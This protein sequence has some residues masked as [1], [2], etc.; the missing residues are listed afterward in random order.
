M[1]DLEGLIEELG[2]GKQVRQFM[3][4]HREGGSVLRQAHRRSGDGAEELIG[5]G[6]IGGLVIEVLGVGDEELLC[7]GL[8]GMEEVGMEGAGSSRRGQQKQS[9]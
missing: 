4:V 7:S 5:S 8:V 9:N 6:I 3:G 1:C 2:I